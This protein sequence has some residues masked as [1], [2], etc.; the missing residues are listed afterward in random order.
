MG[1]YTGT[2][3]LA[4]SAFS[5]ALNILVPVPIIELS[6]MLRA[7]ALFLFFAGIAVPVLTR[8]GISNRMSHI[9]TTSASLLGVIPYF[10]TLVVVY[11]FPISPLFKEQG[12]YT[13]T[14]FGAAFFA[15]LI[16]RLLIMDAKQ[17]PHWHRYSLILAFITWSGVEVMLVFTSPFVELT[18]EYNL[19][20]LVG[21]LLVFVWLLLALYWIIRPP[22]K[23]PP[24][25]PPYWISVTSIF[26]IIILILTAYIQTLLQT[27]IPVVDFQLIFRGWLLPV[28]YVS[29]FIILILFAWF[30]RFTRGEI[31]ITIIALGLLSLWVVT[32]FI[33]VNFAD[34]TAGWWSA[35]FILLFGLF[36][37]PAV[38]GR[39]HL[40][41]LGR[42]RREQQR[43]LLYS[44]ILVHDLRNYH[45]VLDS[46]V[47]L[48]RY[49]ETAPE[50]REMAYNEALTSLQRAE[51]LISNVRM[52]DQ[53]TNLD[54]KQFKP[55]DLVATI[56]LAWEHVLDAIKVNDF[57][58]VIHQ[59]PEEAYV[60]ANDLLL[61]VF[62]NLFRNAVTYSP[63]EKRIHVVIQS[64][65]EGHRQTWQIQ[66]VDWGK[67]ILD[68]DKL[69]LFKRYT[70]GSTGVGLG[71]SVV[72]S[73]VTA[74]GGTVQ[75]DN[76]VPHDYSRGTVFTV[77]LPAYDV[78]R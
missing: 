13:I 50:T 72:R 6:I 39:V 18:G 60:F 11:L 34:W 64:S 65:Q 23:D 71:L 53:A 70:Q 48:L 37:G 21:N 4:T 56:D 29:L 14:H 22:T 68:E 66:I 58:F 75:V 41:V 27:L 36:I 43:T 31:S 17:R 1:F 2:L 20:Y 69:N 38:I 52:I 7:A 33:K 26:I 42:V 54:V 44:D 77:I 51:Q 28:C 55:V 25:N 32:N 57:E 16:S 3:L 78:N 10:V 30:L 49:N 15:A 24:A 9:Y 47:E 5:L 59:R 12:I 19:Q 35:E 62:V 46:A 45:Q 40:E 76:R 73:L 74:F 67:G 63:D 61:E 8:M